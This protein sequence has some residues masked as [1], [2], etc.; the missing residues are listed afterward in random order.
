MAVF[1]VQPV[2]AKKPTF[3]PLTFVETF[4]IVDCTFVT[5]LSSTP[6]PPGC[7]RL[8][9][10]PKF[11]EVP[12]LLALNVASIAWCTSVTHCFLGSVEALGEPS[13]YSR[14]WFFL[15]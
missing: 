15:V 2:E 9:G 14:K 11:S 3:L 1:A 12:P 7:S 5:A 13:R 8:D 4:L 10:T 6:L